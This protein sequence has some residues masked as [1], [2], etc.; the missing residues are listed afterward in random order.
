MI[1]ANELRVGN[2]VKWGDK[3]MVVSYHHIRICTIKE[4]E[5]NY[6][7]IPITPKILEG[8]GFYKTGDIFDKGRIELHFNPELG[9]YR[10]NRVDGGAT[11]LYYLHELQNLYFAL[12]GEELQCKFIAGKSGA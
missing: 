10:Y 7:P 2:L 11:S 5:N 1:E 8:C 9:D 12:T 6:E 3:T 4:K